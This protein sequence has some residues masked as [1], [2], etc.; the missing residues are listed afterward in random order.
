M[1][2]IEI[3]GAVTDPE[4]LWNPVPIVR[5]VD[6]NGKKFMWP[7]GDDRPI[8]DYQHRL[9]IQCCED[10]Y[11]FGFNDARGILLALWNFG[12]REGR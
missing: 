9:T 10:T 7:E 6:K 5:R 8:E 1:M 4:Y 2:D 11:R 12:M 3:K